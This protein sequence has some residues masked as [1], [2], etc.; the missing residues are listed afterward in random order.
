MFKLS[1]SG[2]A[3]FFTLASQA[4]A[5]E[6]WIYK[7]ITD[8]FTDKTHYLAKISS[9]LAP[10]P[11]KVGFECRNGK[12]FVFVSDMNENL[13]GRNLEFTLRYRVGN[14]RSKKIKMRTYSNSET[15]GMNRFNAIDIANDV[16]NADRLRIRIISSGGDRYDAE[17]PLENSKAAIL[18]TVEACGL[19][20]DR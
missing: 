16:L 20:V 11:L 7:E 18:K 10:N 2:L 9:G 1:L 3:L 4:G 19:N 17:V 8:G 13:G 12:Q 14:K 15:G 5:E 6:K